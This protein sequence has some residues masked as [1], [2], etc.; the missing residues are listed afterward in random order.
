MLFAVKRTR[1]LFL[2]ILYTNTTPLLS[3][4]Y[5]IDQFFG[6]NTKILFHFLRNHAL[7]S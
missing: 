7:S 5:L 6:K 1:S 3:D 4:M 2:Y